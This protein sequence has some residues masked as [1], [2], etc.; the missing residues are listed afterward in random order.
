MTMIFVF[1]NSVSV[2]KYA[3]HLFNSF[4]EV[5]FL[6]L[7]WISINLPY[8]HVWNTVVTSGLLPLVAIWNC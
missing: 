2:N 1:E 4:Y 8:A 3:M 6:R 5:S 7:L